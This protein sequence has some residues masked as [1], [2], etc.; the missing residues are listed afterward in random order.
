M[1]VP[2][3]ASGASTASCHSCWQPARCCACPNSWTAT[4]LRPS[5]PSWARQFCGA[6]QASSTACPQLSCRHGAHDPSAHA[7]THSLCGW[8]AC[9]KDWMITQWAPRLANCAMQGPSA[10]T[11]IALINSLANVGGL[12]GPAITGKPTGCCTCLADHT[13][14]MVTDFRRAARPCRPPQA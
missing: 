7:M 1:H 10:A 3:Q 2:V 14:S 9:R 11:G 13:S 4:P 5:S 8:F 12:I 6:L